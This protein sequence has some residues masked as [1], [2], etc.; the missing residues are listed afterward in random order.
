[1]IRT[2]I[3][4][5]EQNDRKVFVLMEDWACSTDNGHGIFAIFDSEEKAKTVL[6]CETRDFRT[7]TDWAAKLDEIELTETSVSMSCTT[8]FE[9]YHFEMWIEQWTI[10]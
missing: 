1:M 7:N 4:M 5:N 10:G 2:E 9:D 8:E 6:G 3:K